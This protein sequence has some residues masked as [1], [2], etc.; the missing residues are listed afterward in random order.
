MDS[1]RL[2]GII[3]PAGLMWCGVSALNRGESEM[4]ATAALPV[5]GVDLA[6]TVFQLA[7]ADAN[8]RVVERQRLTRTQFE[9]WFANRAV[10]QVVMAACGSAHYW[11]RWLTALGIEVR[12]LR[13]PSTALACKRRRPPAVAARRAH[14]TPIK[15]RPRHRDHPHHHSTSGGCSGCG[16]RRCRGRTWSSRLPAGRRRSRR[17]PRGPGRGLR[18]RRGS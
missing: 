15:R 12:L 10:G 7:V 4:N 3:V 2:L 6:K 5:V 14:P 1:P 11:A 18:R 13:Q 9:R 17:T 16:E 8:S